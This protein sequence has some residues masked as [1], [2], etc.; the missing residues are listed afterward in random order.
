MRLRG[1]W[2]KASSERNLG[3]DNGARL[4]QAKS[5]S[6]GAGIAGDHQPTPHL[7]A[8]V[9]A[10]MPVDGETYVACRGDK[11]S[12]AEEIHTVDIAFDEDARRIG[13]V[14]AEL[15]AGNRNRRQQRSGSRRGGVMH[16]VASDLCC[17]IDGSMRVK[18]IDLSCEPEMSA[19]SPDNVV[20]IA[21]S[22]HR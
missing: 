2:I 12:I 22:V 21:R 13:Q 6:V 4:S 8:R 3:S 14:I 15:R 7:V 17:R 1:E 18:E 10:D 20:L 9:Y 16:P 19:F 11:V 5:D